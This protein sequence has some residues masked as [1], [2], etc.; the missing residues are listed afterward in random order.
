MIRYIQDLSSFVSLR[1]DKFVMF[2][3]FRKCFNAHSCSYYFLY[4][5]RREIGVV[6]N[7][8]V[9]WDID[10][11]KW[12][13]VCNISCGNIQMVFVLNMC[14]E[15]SGMNS[16]ICSFKFV[17]VFEAN[18]SSHDVVLLHNITAARAYILSM[19]VDSYML[20]MPVDFYILSTNS[21]LPEINSIMYTTESNTLRADPSRS[22]H[23]RLHST[24]TVPANG[25]M[26]LVPGWMSQ[27]A[28]CGDL[29][30]NS[31][32]SQWWTQCGWNFLHLSSDRDLECLDAKEFAMASTREAKGCEFCI[33]TVSHQLL[34]ARVLHSAMILVNWGV[35]QDSATG[36]GQD[37]ASGLV[38]SSWWAGEYLLAWT[39]GIWQLDSAV[40]AGADDVV[41]KHSG[42]PW[43]RLL[44]KHLHVTWTWIEPNMRHVNYT[45]SILESSL[46][47]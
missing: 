47:K 43:Y 35:V 2:S 6:Q 39:D 42:G 38:R 27:M 16:V 15:G 34:A 7:S 25:R 29:I 37:A 23:L 14:I 20:S 31:I 3:C 17:S 13:W 21:D 1:W 10:F 32:T 44:K 8:L 9:S 28:N 40:E 41:W 11:Y 30:W 36:V 22:H 12:Q 33:L 26:E 18:F 45:S 19:P 46:K 5:V 4:R 24:H